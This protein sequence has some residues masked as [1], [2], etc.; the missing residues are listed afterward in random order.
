LEGVCELLGVTE[1]QLWPAGEVVTLVVKLIGVPAVVLATAI[2]RVLGA[3][4]PAMPT[5]SIA[6]GVAV[7]TFA[8]P[9]FKVTGI[10]MGVLVPLP[11]S[12]TVIVPVQLLA[13]VMP[14]VTG[15]IVIRPGRSCPCASNSSVEPLDGVTV[16]NPGQLVAFEV[17]V[18]RNGAPELESSM[19]CAAGALCPTWNWN[20]AE[21]GAALNVAAPAPAAVTV[22]VTGN[23]C[24]VAP[25]AVKFTV[26]VYVPACS[27]V[28]ALAAIDNCNVA[29]VVADVGVTVKNCGVP[30][31]FAEMLNGFP[32]LLIVT[33]CAAGALPPTWKLKFVGVVGTVI[34]LPAASVKLTGIV[35]GVVDP[36]AR[37]LTVPWQVP[38]GNALGFA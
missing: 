7:T 33:V 9:A 11:S 8:V 37:M 34:E 13:L 3:G 36:V 20:A 10:V 22:N 23:D 30:V 26:F 38:A 1:S 28:N 15:V 4:L 29:G 16:K 32:V 25:L 24:A 2:V 31:T 19:L 12:V 17:T 35:T 18:Y 27:P 5:A 14:V 21:V 6:I